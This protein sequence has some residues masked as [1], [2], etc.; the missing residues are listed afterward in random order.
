MLHQYGSNIHLGYV[1][2]LQCNGSGIERISVPVAS[3]S[4]R[5]VKTFDCCHFGRHNTCSDC[6][7]ANPREHRLWDE[8][9][10][11]DHQLGYGKV[12]LPD[13]LSTGYLETFL[14][15]IFGESINETG[16]GLKLC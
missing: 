13:F 4:L 3:N 1:C 9:V 15:G 14:D 7:R 8:H 6:F 12:Y 5:T 10:I 16:K 11:I 2:K